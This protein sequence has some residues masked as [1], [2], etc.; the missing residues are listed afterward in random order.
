MER[1]QACPNDWDNSSHS[2]IS[3]SLI[4]RWE[5]ERIKEDVVAKKAARAFEIKHGTRLMQGK[6]FDCSQGM[7]S[8]AKDGF[9]YWDENNEGRGYWFCRYCGSNHVTLT[10]NDGVVIEQGDLYGSGGFPKD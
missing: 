10:L 9:E 7:L 3:L 2:P 6:C 5:F 4:L 8:P 1:D